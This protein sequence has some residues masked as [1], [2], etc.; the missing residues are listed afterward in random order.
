MRPRILIV[1]LL[2]VSSC[3]ARMTPLQQVQVSHDALATA[4]DLEVQLCLGVPTVAAASSLPTVNHCITAI[5]TTIGL[6]DARHQALSTHFVTALTIHKALAT[7]AAS[8]ATALDYATLKATISTILGLVAELRQTADVAR[9][10]S[11][12]KAGQVK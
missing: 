2:L 6:T 4:Q 3:A 9:L 11:T 1:A 7:Q 5:A 8:G 12:V 10:A